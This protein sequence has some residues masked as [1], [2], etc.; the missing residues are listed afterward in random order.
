LIEEY[1]DNIFCPEFLSDEEA[2][3][4][5]KYIVDLKNKSEKQIP[6]KLY[7]NEYN[8]IHFGD[9]VKG[10]CPLCLTEFICITP[11][12]YIANNYGYCKQCGQKIDLDPKKYSK[13]YK[14]DSL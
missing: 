14:N 9:T 3:Y 12:Y 4:L 2:E 11:R 5:Y 13:K 8:P 7:E 1:K 10:L 6:I